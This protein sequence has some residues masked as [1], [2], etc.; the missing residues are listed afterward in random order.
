[1]T[2]QP[3]PTAQF[4]PGFEAD[5]L[6]VDGVEIFYV[7]GGAG[8]PLLL[9][10][11]APQS[12]VMWRRVAADLARRFTLV[13][14]DLRGYGRSGKPARGDYSKRR[15]AADLVAVMDALG[16]ERFYV[17]GHDRGARVTRR[18]VKDHA[19][20]VLKAAILDIVPTAHIYANMSKQAAVNLWNWCLWPA[21][22][23][24]PETVLDPR[25]VV[26]LTARQSEP[27]ACEDYLHTNG[28][29]EAL[30]AMC[31][32]YRAGASID[33]EHDAADADR[34]IRVP[35]LILWGAKSV[36]TGEL[37]DVQAAWRPEG[38]DLHFRSVEAGH[39]IPEEAPEE[40]VRAL[41]EFFRA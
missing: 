37:F 19:P 36:S 41:V 34:P 5:R 28:N 31:E 40:T 6:T 25:G 18:L 2:A 15:M 16:H 26:Y 12:H 11:G 7:T 17:A 20:R 29:A 32:D 39:F 22:E 4:F 33:L 24:I 23:P 38:S 35:T 8:P 30:H 27:A 3:A 10:H 1:M 14:P 9:V 13:I 21:R